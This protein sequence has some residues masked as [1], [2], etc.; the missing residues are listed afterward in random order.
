M[1]V[2]FGAHIS[3]SKGLVKAVDR[4]NDLGCKVMQIFSQ[5]PQSFRGISKKNIDAVD[6]ARERLK[7]HGIQVVSHSPY[8][9]NLAKDPVKEKYVADALKRDLEFVNKLEGIGS[10]VHMGKSIKLSEKD[11]LD[12][13]EKNIKNILKEYKGKSKLILETSCGQGTELLFKIEDLGKFYQRFTNKEKERIGFCI[14][15][16][17]VF[18]A[19]YDMRTASKV[20][21]FMKLFDDSI[22]LDNLVLIHFNDSDKPFASHVDRHEDIGKGFIGKKEGGSLSGLKEVFKTAKKLGVPMTLETHDIEGDL[23][24][25]QS[26]KEYK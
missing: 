3:I 1:S 8:L 4:A 18:V 25:V 26:W 19:G 13:M 12:N 24:N 16:C 22:G 5:S 23:K 20:K 15:T 21:E 9:I 2:I 17:H 6:K 7:H 10:V 14:D 11:A